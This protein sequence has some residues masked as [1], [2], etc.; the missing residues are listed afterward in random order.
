MYGFKNNRIETEFLAKYFYVVDRFI[1]QKNGAS[2]KH[3]I[4]LNDN[5]DMMKRN[6]EFMQFENLFNSEMCFRDVMLANRWKCLLVRR[7]CII[8]YL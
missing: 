2:N 7:L 8:D 6:L 1:V 3:I 5:S 4:N